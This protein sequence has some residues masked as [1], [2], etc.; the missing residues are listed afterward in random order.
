MESLPN[1]EFAFPGPL[2]DALVAAILA[3][4][5]TSTTSL[6]LQYDDDGGEPLPRPGD[7]SILVDSG[8]RPLAVLEVTEIRLGRLGTVDLQHV[9]DEGEGHETLEEWRAAHE[10]FWHS[11]ELRGVLGD[12][13]FTVDDDTVVLME[14]F[15]VVE[16]LPAAETAR[17]ATDGA[18]SAQAR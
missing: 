17:T 12:P 16:L 7:R 18:G 14:R 8:E 11:S 6:A 10:E 15:R 3:G 2:R 4:S 13:S 1:A 5:K 9:R